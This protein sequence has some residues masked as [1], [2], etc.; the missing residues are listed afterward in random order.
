M[1]FVFSCDHFDGTGAIWSKSHRNTGKL[2]VQWL[3]A[4][5][6]VFMGLMQFPLQKTQTIASHKTSKWFILVQSIC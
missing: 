1:F 2:F 6:Q 4:V 3:I 5:M